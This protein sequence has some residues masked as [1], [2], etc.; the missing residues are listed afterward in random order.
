MSGAEPSTVQRASPLHLNRAKSVF[1]WYF[2][3][4]KQFINITIDVGGQEFDFHGLPDTL[5]TM[6]I[7]GFQADP[8][9]HG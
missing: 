7:L 3:I 2:C 6:P 5:V 4:I 1:L 9:P 8:Q